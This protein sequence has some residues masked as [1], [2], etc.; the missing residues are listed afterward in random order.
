MQADSIPT[1]V[2]NHSRKGVPDKCQESGPAARCE[3]ARA[4]VAAATVPV[5]GFL[6]LAERYWT[7]P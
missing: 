4:A 5:Q 6:A 1:V 7:L 3:H 2:E